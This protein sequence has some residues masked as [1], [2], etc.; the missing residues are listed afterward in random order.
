MTKLQQRQSTLLLAMLTSI[1]ITW[2]AFRNGTGAEET[3]SALVWTGRL[4]F[5]VFL[6]PFFASPLWALFKNKYV[7]RLMRWR[8]NSGIAYGGIQVI[9]LFIIAWLFN[10]SSSQPVDDDMLYIGGL[11][12][13]LVM[14]M[15]VT[16][17]DIPTKMIGKRG[18]KILHKSGF[19]ICS[20]IYF[21]DFVIE[22]IELGTAMQYLP[23]AAIT[24]LAMTLRTIVWLKPKRA[25]AT[26]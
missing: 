2:V 9:H 7:A 10:I 15:L 24:C 12:L 1:A 17:F 25:P 11:G 3:K 19:Y 4:A 20:L 13:I 8:R 22:P 16:S 5:F 18:W 26:A 6:I 21:Y 14:G 23:F